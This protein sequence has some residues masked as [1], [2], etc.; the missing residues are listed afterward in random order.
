MLCRHLVQ[1]PLRP[2]YRGMNKRPVQAKY[3][4]EN[5]MLTLDYS[6]DI[7]Q[8]YNKDDSAQM[9]QYLQ[10]QSNAVAPVSNYAVGVFRSGQ[11]HLTPVSSILQMRPSL[12]HLDED[13]H[14]D[15][16]DD[17]AQSKPVVQ[18]TD[19]VKEVQVQFKKRQSERALAAIQ[20]SYAYKRSLIQSEKWMEL[21]VNPDEEDE[22]EHLF[23]EIEDSV[24]F[25]ITPSA[26]LRALS[27]RECEEEQASMECLYTEKTT[28]QRVFAYLLTGNDSAFYGVF[29]HDIGPY[30]VLHFK[31][32]QTL[33][34]P[35][36][37]K[38]D[39]MSSVSRVSTIVRGCLVPKCSLMTD[40]VKHRIAIINEVDP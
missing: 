37:S 2:A 24:S 8:N 28:D 5:A 32:L 39:L 21:H 6:V 35:T 25:D 27:Y 40:H 30:K 29:A 1:F 14:E 20:S 19:D 11:L 15:D 26:Y 13:N 22:F 18:K 17:K 4:P 38:E 34:G 33:L 3:K 7:D 12:H 9:S 23:S 10:L 31:Q 16:D 36:V